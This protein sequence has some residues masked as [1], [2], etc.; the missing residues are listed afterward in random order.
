MPMS[1][2]QVTHIV[3]ALALAINHTSDPNFLGSLLISNIIFEINHG[4]QVDIQLLFSSSFVAFCVI[5]YK[6]G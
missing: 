5:D 2:Q 4:D 3:W 6:K 1:M